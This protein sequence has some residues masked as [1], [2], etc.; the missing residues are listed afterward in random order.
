MLNKCHLHLNFSPIHLI[1]GIC[2]EHSRAFWYIHIGL[3]QGYYFPSFLWRQTL[4]FV[5]F[6]TSSLYFC[7]IPNCVQFAF[8]YQ[9]AW[10]L[11]LMSTLGDKL[12][13][14]SRDPSLLVMNHD[15]PGSKTE[16]AGLRSREK[17]SLS[18]A[19]LPGRRGPG[20]AVWLLPASEHLTCRM[21]W[22][23]QSGLSM[24]QAGVLGVMTWTPA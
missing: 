5:R 16:F 6:H 17:R 20:Q 8:R 18:G 22:M 19:L 2:R 24:G 13:F 9:V 10:S 7:V 1:Y 3:C 11:Y 12:I 14:V 23:H 15:T 21:R 4:Q